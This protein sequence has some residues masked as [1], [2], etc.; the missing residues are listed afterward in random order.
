MDL[1]RKLHKLANMSQE[2]RPPS[3]FTLERA[4][5]RAE[6]YKNVQSPTR[7]LD[8][9]YLPVKRVVEDQSIIP[10]SAHH[11][12]PF[13]NF[14]TQ[15]RVLEPTFIPSIVYSKIGNTVK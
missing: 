10:G 12:L 6:I 7:A 3:L 14:Y 8:D 9:P 11:T 13:V 2:T 1:Q 4:R 5:Q 15:K